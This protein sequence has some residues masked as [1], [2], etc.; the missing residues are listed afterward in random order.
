MQTTRN[1]RRPVCLSWLFVCVSASAWAAAPA[2]DALLPRTVK[3]YVSVAHAKEF[4]ERWDKTQLGQLFNDDTMQAFVNDL[5]K[6]AN[7][8]FGSVERKLGIIWEDL[9]GVTG[10]E[11]SLSLIERKN[12]PEAALALT[13]DVTGHEQ[14]AAGFIA[15]AE[16]RFAARGGRKSTLNVGGTT[17]F[18]FD[19]PADKVNK[20]QR[21]V[22]FIKDNLLCGID[23]L[24]EAEAMLKRFGGGAND[25][26]AS[27]VAY[28]EIM[29]RCQKEAGALKPEARWFI[30]PFGFVFAERTMRDTERRRT[31]DL[32]KILYDNGFNAI[33]GAGGHLNQLVEGHIEY[34]LRTAIYAP[35]VKGKE[36]D[37]LRWTSSMRMMQFVNAPPMQPQSWVPRMVANY[38]SVNINLTAAFDNLGPLFDAIQEHEDAWKNTL[39]GWSTDPYGPQVEVRKEFIGNLNNR[40]SVITT[41]DTPITP[42]SERSLFA[43][44][45]KNER[46]LAKTL[47]KWMKNE[48]D[49][50]RHD[51]GQYVIFERTRKANAVQ[52]PEV[53]VPGFTKSKAKQNNAKKERERVLPNSAVTVAFGHLMLAS[54]INYLTN[55][56]QGFGQNEWLGSSMDYE[57][58]VA[59]LAKLAPGD[60]CAWGFGRG[61]EEVRPMFE[62]IRENRMPESKS[63][64][65]KLLNNLL[66]TDEDRKA[67]TP[68]KQRVDGANLPDFE[69]VRRYFGPHARAVRADAD[70]W[71]ITEAVMNTEAP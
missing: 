26:L 12:G 41:Y 69:S 38:M 48:R 25:N 19:I 17:L 28:A 45:A 42:D 59:V 52:E 20:Q 54:D 53:E 1:F 70:G 32:V 29:N 66:T 27:V 57:Q 4:D 46:E 35:A 15:A 24:A 44:E 14:E 18:V 2:S 6:Q 7:D 50:V 62:M 37:P 9:K 30:E 21:T 55:V 61:D 11:L 49:V 60:Q 8:E 39:E 58:L 22:Y 40:V 51:V 10:G 67:G 13:I 5:R 3:G 65:G 71:F 36:N 47:E 43:I 63:M 31:Q 68:R 64:V 34:L 56:L 23:D 33:Q 16:K